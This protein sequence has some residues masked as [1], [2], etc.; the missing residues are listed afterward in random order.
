MAN[1]NYGACNKK[2]IIITL[3]I[4]FNLIPGLFFAILIGNKQIICG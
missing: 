2:K 3:L 1:T 4:I